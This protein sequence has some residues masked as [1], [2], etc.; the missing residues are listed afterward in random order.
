VSKRWNEQ[1]DR[2]ILEL[3]DDYRESIR[4]KSDKEIKEI[5]WAT[6]ERVY[7]TYECL[8]ECTVQAIYE[9]ISYI[10]DLLASDR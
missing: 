7:N 5:T 6:A 2:I 1:E 9:R 10:D 4:D 3:L 8:Q